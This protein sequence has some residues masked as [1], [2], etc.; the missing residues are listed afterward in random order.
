MFESTHDEVRP[1]FGES[2]MGRQERNTLNGLSGSDFGRWIGEAIGEGIALGTQQAFDQIGE[3]L[4]P[5]V[6][7]MV[8]SLRD[9]LTASLAET[10][11][12]EVQEQV[13]EGTR[14]CIEAGCGEPSLA[15]SL[16]RRHYARKL[17]QERKARLGVGSVSAPRHRPSVAPGGDSV[18]EKKLAAVA[19]I[20][21]RKKSEPAVSL[22]PDLPQPMAAAAPSPSLMP[23]FAAPA[24]TGPSVS[25][26]SVA[27]FFGLNKG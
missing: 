27:R 13:A 20:I 2:D 17:Y 23:S 24:P 26:E 16:C 18:V 22:V 9:G 8:Q 25:V 21:R 7:A 6:E 3:E 15:R 10:V 14:V 19:P 5:I 11:D 1:S 12:S 4:A